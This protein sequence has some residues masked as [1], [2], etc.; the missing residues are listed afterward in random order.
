MTSS[1]HELT[2]L[3]AVDAIQAGQITASAYTNALL[4]RIEARESEVQAWQYLDPQQAR[5]QAT[6]LDAHGNLKSLPLAG[7]AVGVKD[8][9]DTADMPTE[10]GTVLDAG[11]RPL[12]DATV[13]R[14]LREAGA[15]I[16]GKTVTTE[17]AYMQPART[18]NPCHLGHSPGGS[19]S[20][21]AAAVAA[22]MVPVALGTQTNGSV[23]RPAS[24]CGVYALKPTKGLFPTDGVLEEAATLD[25]VGVFARSLEDVAAVTQVL[26]KGG[27]KAQ[28]IPDYVRSAREPLSEARFAFV[29]TPAWP[30]VEDS[31]KA[32][33][34]KLAAALG[35]ACEELVLPPE[36]D[37]AIALHRTIMLAEIALNLGGYYDRGKDRLSAAMRK[38]LEAGRAISAVDYAGA[39]RERKRLYRRIEDLAAPY[40]AI[41][42]PSST[43][44]APLGFETTGDPVF[45]SLWTFLGVPALNLP[46]LTVN[47]LPLG[48]QLTGLRFEEDRLFRAG[49]AIMRSHGLEY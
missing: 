28:A 22:C 17:L 41:L 3:E 26:A 1:L 14:L 20:G 38:A 32:A 6:R 44:P 39:L 12:A 16:M 31:T 36:F 10:N 45:C 25:T 21:S 30:S 24:F 27:E 9:I 43:G 5:D 23:I 19:S 2:A 40:D 7:A 11:R 46:L 29:K 33:F 47:G 49:G 8:I 34:A 48:V 15:A 35:A 18:R 13:V 37:R 4:S 42:T